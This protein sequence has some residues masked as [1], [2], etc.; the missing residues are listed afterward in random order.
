MRL[1]P[2]E[3]DKMMLHYAGE[4]AKKRKE[5]GIKLNYVEAIALIS[6]EIMELA[7]EG[8]KSVAELMS[9]G[10]QILKADDVMDGVAS[11]IHDVQVEVSF[12]DGTKLVTVHTPIEDNGKLNPG[13]YILKD[14]DIILNAGKE[15]IKVAVTNNGDRPIQVGSHFHFF[16]T[17]K[18]LSFD[19][20]KAYGKRLD[21]AS[22]TSVRFEPGETK[23]VELIDFGGNQRLYGFNDLNNGQINQKNK[24]KALEVA[25]A[26]GFIK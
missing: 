11:L 25:K 8:K 12:A 22:G 1:T 2:R 17:N 9:Y 20:E 7:R 26:K 13:E 6:M 24:Q 23:T 14:E 18:L 16:E 3:L 10:K 19:R 5:R 15:S 21:I 4:L